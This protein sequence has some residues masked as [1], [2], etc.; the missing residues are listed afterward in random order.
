MSRT[1]IGVVLL[2][3]ATAAGAQTTGPRT[4]RATRTRTVRATGIGRS[5]ARYTGVRARLMAQRAAQLVAARNLLLKL[6]ATQ[7]GAAERGAPERGRRTRRLRGFRYLPTVFRP[8]GTA[9]ATIEITVIAG[10]KARPRGAFASATQPAGR[11]ATG[12]GLRPSGPIQSR[13]TSRAVRGR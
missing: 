10:K 2:C 13:T 7:Q 4:V 5:P 1:L 12:S 6:A 9:V 11:S 8:D 3:A